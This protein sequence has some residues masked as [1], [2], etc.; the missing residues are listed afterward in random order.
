[1][2]INSKK[3]L[4]KIAIPKTKQ[5]QVAPA[6]DN[7]QPDNQVIDLKRL[8]QA[9]KF[10]GYLEDDSTETAW[11]KLW[12]LIAMGANGGPLTS[13]TIGTAAQLKFPSAVAPPYKFTTSTPQAFVE[14]VMGQI[15]SD[16][17]GDI[18]ASFNGKPA[19]I[20]VDLDIYLGYAR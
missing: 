19:R 8:E 10:S 3:S 6:T 17:T 2:V 15:A 1:M 13:L 7:D 9:I 20:K 18:T 14:N 12:K 4:I 5:T 16:D 11:N